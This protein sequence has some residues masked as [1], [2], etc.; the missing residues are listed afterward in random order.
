MS[1]FR[2]WKWAL[3]V[4]DRQSI[5]MPAGAQILTVQTQYGVP[6]LWALCD[7]TLPLTPR[8]FHIYGTGNVIRH[9]V[10]AGWYVG[11]FQLSDGALVF[12]VFEIEK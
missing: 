8:I 5:S 4:V 3:D 11:T 6:Q 9:S 10:A 1:A 7:T 2:I 12:H